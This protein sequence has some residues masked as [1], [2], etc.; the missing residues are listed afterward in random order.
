MT[1]I[2]GSGPHAARDPF[3]SRGHVCPRSCRGWVGHSTMF[4]PVCFAVV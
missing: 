1:L 4:V 3:A 2:R